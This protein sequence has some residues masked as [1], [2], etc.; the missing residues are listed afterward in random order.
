MGRTTIQVDEAV[1][2]ELRSYKADKGVTYD[3]AITVLLRN[4]KWQFRHI[5]SKENDE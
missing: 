3:G 2:D 5:D 4:D 1:R